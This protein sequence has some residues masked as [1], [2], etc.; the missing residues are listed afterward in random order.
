MADQDFK[1]NIVTLADLTGIKL[2]QQQ[3]TALQTAAA[4]GNKDAI[5]ALR[6][7][8]D[9]QKKAAEEARKAQQEFTQGIRA[10]AGYGLIIGGAVAKAINDVAAGQEKVTK[11]L[12]K[13]FESLVKNVQQWNKLAQAATTPSDLASIGEKAIGQI[14]EIHAKW[15]ATYSEERTLW[16]SLTNEISHMFVQGATF[17]MSTYKGVL[18]EQ[19]QALLKG[20][21]DA[22]STA[23]DRLGDTIR[24][25]LKEQQQAHE[26]IAAEILRETKYLDE[27]KAKLLRLDI[28]DNTQS[29]IE[30]EKIVERV[31][32]RLDELLKK[33]QQLQS[34]G[35]PTTGAG[36][37]QSQ[38]EKLNA[39]AARKDLTPLEQTQVRNAQ[40]ATENALREEQLRRQRE[41]R[42]AEA[43]AVR[44]RYEKGFPVQPGQ[45]GLPQSQIGVNDQL[46]KAIDQ[47][48]I[49]LRELRDLWR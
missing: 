13:Q 46:L 20:L 37:L 8:S 9:A 45:A 10:A 43:Q 25:G 3:L 19:R 23:R 30:Q 21:S 40:I 31:S 11:E 1:I 15:K 42:D 7:L 4:A 18:E 41:L 34:Q 29:W 27:Q 36:N 24:T 39:T 28:N 22:E 12:D 6:K 47:Q 5:E 33:Y 26:N 44:D 14:D 17:G 38:L 48:N 2:T 16:Q 32:N 49:F 35:G